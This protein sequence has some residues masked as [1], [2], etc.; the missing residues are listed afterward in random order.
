MRLRLDFEQ[1]SYGADEA[2]VGAHDDGG[3]QSEDYG[4]RDD[5]P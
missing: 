3:E 1:R 4:N 2:A 5:H